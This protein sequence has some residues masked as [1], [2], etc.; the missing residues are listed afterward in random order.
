MHC[1]YTLGKVCVVLIVFA[2][3]DKIIFQFSIPFFLYNKYNEK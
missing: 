2:L 3:K 1:K